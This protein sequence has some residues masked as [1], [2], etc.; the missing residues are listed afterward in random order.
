MSYLKLYSALGVDITDQSGDQAVG[1]CPF[2]G[3]GK[4]GHWYGSVTRGQWKCHKCGRSG[5]QYTMMHE[6][7]MQ[8]NRNLAKDPRRVARLGKRRGGLPAKAFAGW[9]LGWRND[10][11][12]FTLPVMGLSAGSAT[13]VRSYVPGK[14]WRSLPGCTLGMMGLNRLARTDSD[15]PVWVCEGEWDAMSLSWLLR[16][17][18]RNDVVLAVPGASVWKQPW[19]DALRGRNVRL[20]YDHDS[21]GEMGDRRAWEA[22]QG[23]VGNIKSV[24]W[25]ASCPTG[26]DISDWVRTGAVEQSIPRKCLL[27]LEGCLEAKPVLPV[28]GLGGVTSDKPVHVGKPQ[29]T[30][31]ELYEVFRK[32][33]YMET[34]AMLAIVLGVVMA[35]RL[36]G[37]PVWLFIQTPPGGSKSE[38]L[39]AIGESDETFS[40]SSLSGHALVSGEKRGD[41]SLLPLLDGK[42]LVVKDFTVML[43]MDTGDRQAVFSQLRDAF[44]GRFY[45]RYGNGVVREYKG[46]H[47]GMVAGATPILEVHQATESSLGERF[48]RF[49]PDDNLNHYKQEERVLRAMKNASKIAVMQEELRT[50]VQRYLRGERKEPE[51]TS[52]MERRIYDL[53]AGC[54]RM[55]GSVNRN[56]ARPYLQDSAPFKEVPTR[57]AQQLTQL[58]KGIA[59]YYGRERVGKRELNLVR[60]VAMDSIPDRRYMVAQVLTGGPHSV[61]QC[62]EKIERVTHS[63]ITRIMDDLFRLDAV[64]RTK[65]GKAN[66]YQL[67]GEARTLF[68]NGR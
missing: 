35:T 5:N 54:A 60:R 66:Q 42:V 44:D 28:P 40:L 22:L 2:V 7:A 23:Q 58:A 29:M 45:R 56:M 55:R 53:A 25:L 49:R 16:S 21:A 64:G 24:H 19:T 65:L 18:K 48:L 39:M 37:V 63:T 59:M 3:C 30:S 1:T 68:L 11:G 32:W 27:A 61:A 31:D 14:S 43:E 6:L 38:M 17:L 13:D 9:K 4:A 52:K 51:L 67:V 62:A 41:P 46:F 34:D 20:C 33:L 26:W 36:R 57:L 47:F 15:V 8:W 50:A 10:R 12:C